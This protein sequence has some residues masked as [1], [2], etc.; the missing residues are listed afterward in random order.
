MASKFDVILRIINNTIANR[1]ADV[2]R[3]RRNLQFP[4][5]HEHVHV[6]IKDNGNMLCDWRDMSLGSLDS[7]HA[8]AHDMLDDKE[9]IDDK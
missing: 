8:W 1:D 7:L 9:K 3:T 5:P 6:T 2:A 4:P